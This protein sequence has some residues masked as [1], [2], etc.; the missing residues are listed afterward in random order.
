MGLCRRAGARHRELRGEAP[1]GRSVRELL[2]EGVAITE[3]GMH[4]HIQEGKEI[5]GGGKRLSRYNER[6]GKQGKTKSFPLENNELGT[7]LEHVEA[8]L[9]RLRAR[10]YNIRATAVRVQHAAPRHRGAEAV[11][12]RRCFQQDHFQRP[13]RATWRRLLLLFLLGPRARP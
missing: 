1:G 6:L 11:R 9:D 12:E 7:Y 10:G 4:I 2:P 8:C 5:I 13:K 3:R